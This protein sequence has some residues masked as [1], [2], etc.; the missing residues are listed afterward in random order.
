MKKLIIN[1]NSVVEIRPRCHFQVE[2]FSSKSSMVFV[3]STRFMIVSKNMVIQNSNVHVNKLFASVMSLDYKSS[4]VKYYE[5]SFNEGNLFDFSRAWDL[6]YLI[7]KNKQSNVPNFFILKAESVDFALTDTSALKSS[8]IMIQVNSFEM[9]DSSTITGEI[10]LE[11]QEIGEN[12]FN[13]GVKGACHSGF[14]YF[15]SSISYT[16][17]LDNF[18]TKS[19]STIDNS[20]SPEITIGNCN[21]QVSLPS[22]IESTSTS[23]R[24][25]SAR[26]EES[27]T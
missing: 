17:C 10:H 9:D 16:N 27:F 20:D 18:F 4:S 2:E 11:A 26:R 3:D 19:F 21:S 12:E 15:G 13:C 25:S 6:D 14:G 8:I 1:P 7:D 22:S 23:V 5:E 24:N